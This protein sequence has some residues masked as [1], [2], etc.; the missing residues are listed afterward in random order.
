MSAGI[1]AAVGGA[2]VGGIISSGAQKKAAKSASEAQIYAA[3]LGVEEQRAQREE[4]SRQFEVQMDEYRRKQE[5]LEQQYE[6]MQTQLAPYVQAGQGAL[7]EMMALSGMAAPGSPVQT[8]RTPDTGL[9]Q[10]P[11]KGTVPRGGDFQV[12]PITSQPSPFRTQLPGDP[13]M[14]QGQ[15]VGEGQFLRPD[16][17]QIQPTGPGQLLQPQTTASGQQRLF[18]RRA[19]VL[20]L[21]M[22]KGQL[23]MV[24]VV[25]F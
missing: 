18:G 15:P 2:L 19:G 5:L 12:D 16:M 13:M 4:Q 10:F 24:V 23:P 8:G 22:G 21:L 20:P 9:P 14:R 25:V 7:F 3:E 11:A 1:A 17:L 6:K